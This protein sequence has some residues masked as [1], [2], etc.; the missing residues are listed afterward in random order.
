MGEFFGRYQDKIVGTDGIS[1]SEDY[2]NYYRF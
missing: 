1:V 2:P